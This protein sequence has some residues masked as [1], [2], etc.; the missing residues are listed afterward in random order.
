MGE[1]KTLQS[2]VVYSVVHRVKIYGT[3]YT[4]NCIT[5]SLQF[6]WGKLGNSYLVLGKYATIRIGREIRCLLNAGF[7]FAHID[8]FQAFLAH[9]FEM[10]DIGH[11]ITKLKRCALFGLGNGTRISYTDIPWLFYSN[12]WY[13]YW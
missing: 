4:R 6:F 5:A 13:F 11:N 1:G 7:V 9:L 10:L 8:F 2:M 12:S 3:F